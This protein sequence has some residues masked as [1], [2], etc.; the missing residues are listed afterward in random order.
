MVELPPA[1]S[2][3]LGDERLARLAAGRPLLVAAFSK[4]LATAPTALDTVL[5]AL[6]SGAVTAEAP[7]LPQAAALYWDAVSSYLASQ[8]DS[9]LVFA[10]RLAWMPPNRIES[11]VAGDDEQARAAL[12]AVGLLG[13]STS[14]DASSM[15]RVFGEVIRASTTASGRAERVVRELLELPAARISLLR[16]SDTAT[17]AALAEAVAHT[18]AS[19]LAM[20]ALATLQEAYQP[21]LATQTFARAR[22]LL[23]PND[24]AQATALADCLYAAARVVNQSRQAPEADFVAVAEDLL[25]G[26][27]LRSPDD[28]AGI[29]RHEGLLA[30]IRMRAARYLQDPAEKVQALNE[31]RDLL[32]A[33]WLRRRAAF[34]DGDPMTDRANYNRAGVN[35]SLARMKAEMASQA[36]ADGDLTA[37][38][39]HRASAKKHLTEAGQVYRMAADTRKRYYSRSNPLTAAA[40]H[41]IA[42]CG[43]ELI[44]LGLADD[45]EMVLG[46][47][48]DAVAEALTIRRATGLDGDIVRSAS[49]LAS[50]GILEIMLRTGEPGA[51]GSP[52]G[53]E[54]ADILTRLGLRD[55]A[56]KAL[57]YLEGS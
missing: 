3:Q 14:P 35:V 10:E 54:V 28:Q 42:L 36:A 32:E 9:P 49:L 22:L 48:I 39:E 53:R 2:G 7:G 24:P 41:G 56:L 38:A 47:S 40:I 51:L 19:G 6:D 26:M 25:Y 45:P 33:S 50:L 1:P 5:N 21:A 46:E 20:W 8:K 18:T 23:D 55:P 31:A 16:H 17:V 37:E 13:E 44:L 29:A 11:G 27:T 30:L 52:A 57:G 15:H 12:G 43:Q 4:L 34:G